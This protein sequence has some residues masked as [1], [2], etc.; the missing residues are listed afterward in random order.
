MSRSSIRR[1][2][3]APSG[4]TASVRARNFGERALP[5]IGPSPR[6]EVSPRPAAEPVPL[7]G[8]DGSR[9]Q[10]QVMGAGDEVLRP[11][12]HR[13]LALP[14]E[15]EHLH[16]H[17]DALELEHLVEDER[18]RELREPGH[19]VR[20]PKGMPAARV[21]SHRHSGRPLTR[22]DRGQVR[23]QL[24]VAR[25]AGVPRVRRHDTFARRGR[26]VAPA[27]RGRRAG[28]RA[29]RRRPPGRRRPA[30]PVRA[31]CPGSRLRGRSSRSDA[32]ST[33]PRAACS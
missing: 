3:A 21:G 30:G 17:A 15:R 18:L 31:R 20:D 2:N 26:R 23:V 33:S 29:P 14:D 11:R 28:G 13:H 9:R 7:R 8:E 4:T 6:R 12:L 10:A 22:G 5:R 32:R 19:Q 27:A 24:V 1:A 25:G 16:V